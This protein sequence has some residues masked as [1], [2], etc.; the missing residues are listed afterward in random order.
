MCKKYGTDAEGELFPFSEGDVNK[1]E[2][3]KAKG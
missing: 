1:R 2:V 3:R